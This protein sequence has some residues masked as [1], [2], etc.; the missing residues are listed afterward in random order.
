MDPSLSAL[1]NSIY[2]DHL[3]LGAKEAMC[4]HRGRKI[5]NNIKFFSSAIVY[6]YV[7]INYVFS[8]YMQQVIL[9]P[10]TENSSQ[11]RDVGTRTNRMAT[12]STTQGRFQ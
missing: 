8:L 4:L 10:S 7:L 3:L 12:R 6:V 11:I 9:G 5:L 1:A 2:Y